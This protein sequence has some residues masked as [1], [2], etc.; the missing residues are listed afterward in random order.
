MSL[1]LGQAPGQ[2]SSRVRAGKQSPGPLR[3]RWVRRR[4]CSR[5]VPDIRQAELRLIAANAEIGAARAQFFPQISL[6]AFLGG[7][8][9]A[10]SELFT[11]PARSAFITPAAIIPIFHAGQVRANVRLT[12]AQEREALTTYQRTIFVGLRDASDA[13][14]AN[15][16]TREQVNPAGT[17]GGCAARTRRVSRRCAM[18]VGSTVTFKCWTPSEICSKGNWC[19]RSYA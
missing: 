15:D 3:C 19:W 11:N 18:R 16:R 12:E 4:P 8:N 13:L 9:R 6:N 2:Y 1:L 14:I 17:S 5:G 10:V 7:Q